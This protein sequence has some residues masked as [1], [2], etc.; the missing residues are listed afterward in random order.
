LTPVAR[1]AVVGLGGIAEE[2]LTKLRRLPGAE[3]VGICDLSEALVDAVGE[4][5]GVGPGFTDYE[6]M[7]TEARPDAVHVLSPPSTHRELVLAALERGAHVF[8]EK[9]IAPSLAEYEEMRDAAQAKG[10]LLVEN[11]NYLFMSDVQ[12]ALALVRNGDVG[13]LVNFEV[14]MGVGLAGAAYT[15]PVLVH[16]AHQLPGGAMRNFASHPA[17]IVTAFLGEPSMI[18]VSQR[19]LQADLASNDELRALVEDGRRS[20]TVSITSHSRPFEFT[21]TARC[22]A[23]TLSCDVLGQRLSVAWEGSPLSEVRDEMRHGLGRIA[24]AAGRVRRATTS[25]EGYFQGFETLLEGFYESILEGSPPPIAI[26]E[27]DSTN[28]LVEDLFAPE[29]QL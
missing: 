17:S 9:P 16:F 23:A 21:F 22:T 19:R 3:V 1:A 26:E 8:V 10:L 12:R 13:E 24:T 6:A 28:R 18:A 4:R 14:S 25:R 2:H 20:A 7:L 27:M 5:Y 15:D 11:Y 29:N